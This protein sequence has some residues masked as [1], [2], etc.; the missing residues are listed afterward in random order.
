MRIAVVSDIHGNRTA[1][2]AVISDLSQTSPDEILH[3][4]D[5]ADLGARPVEI[6]DRIR[7]LGWRGVIGNGEEAISMPDTM[8]A[9]A[10]QSLAPASLWGAIREM[11]AAIRA[12]LGPERIAWLR[13]LPRVQVGDSFALVH[14]SPESTW[15][16]PGPEARD[17]ELQ[18][19]YGALGRPIVI[20][21]H[22]HRSFVRRLVSPAGGDMLVA[23]SGS[24]SLSYDGDRR[25]AY[26]LLDGGKATIR[27][28]EYDLGKEINELS[29]CSLPHSD[30][31]AKTLVSASPQMP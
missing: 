14:A 12:E 27:R 9:F 29:A 17:A 24:V 31:I 11:M 26:L 4:G 25:A 2:D 15:R 3:G 19:I 30:W 10:S 23:N 20:Y 28:V 21:G 13:E 22:I 1:F 5:L 18:S 6:V 8:E 16:S 7:E